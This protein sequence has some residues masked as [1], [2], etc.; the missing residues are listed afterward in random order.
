METNVSEGGGYA[1]MNRRKLLLAGTGF[2]LAGCTSSRESGASD[3]DDD[4]MIDSKDYA[5]QDPEVQEKED[6]SG[7]SDDGSDSGDNGGENEPTGDLPS[8]SGSHTISGG[9]DYWSM[10]LDIPTKFVLEYTVTNQKEPKYDFDA[11]VFNEGEYKDY[12]S[13][14]GGGM[15]NPNA[16]NKASVENVKESGERTVT[17]SAGVYYFVVDNTDIGAAGDWGAEDTRKVKVELFTRTA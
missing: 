2:L 1:C 3:S 6:V 14:V 15:T 11:F 5:P 17:L 13:K 10:E 9:K 4:G 16:I 12:K 7:G 8:H